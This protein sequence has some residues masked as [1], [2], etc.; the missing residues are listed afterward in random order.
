M[1]MELKKIHLCKISLLMKI[2]TVMTRMQWHSLYDHALL[3]YIRILKFFINREEKS[4]SH[5]HNTEKAFF[6]V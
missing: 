2:E 4:S 6:A 1:C 3:T 5:D